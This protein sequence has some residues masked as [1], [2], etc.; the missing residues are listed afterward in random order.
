MDTTS[1]IN[2]RNLKQW[3]SWAWFV[4]FMQIPFVIW[5]AQGKVPI[6]PVVLMLP[7]IGLR[8]FK[9]ETGKRGYRIEIGTSGSFALSRLFL[10]RVF[11]DRFDYRDAR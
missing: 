11:L 6:H 5:Y 7:L 2:N 9:V 3:A 1:Q 10:C 8:N 4:Y